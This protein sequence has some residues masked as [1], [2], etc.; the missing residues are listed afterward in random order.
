MAKR[1]TDSC[2]WNDGWFSDLPTDMKLVWLYILDTCDHAGVYKLNM[3]LLKFQT[4]T[5]RSREE[6]ENYLAERIYVSGDKWFI[7]K[8]IT[9]QYKNFFTS[10]TPAIISA[11]ELLVSHGI[12]LP[13]DNTLPTVNKQ[14]S[15]AS[16]TLIE[17]LSNDYIRTKDK[18]KAE[19]KD[20]NKDIVKDKSIIQDKVITKTK[21]K[22][23]ISPDKVNTLLFAAALGL[24]SEKFDDRYNDLSDIMDNFT[25]IKEFA[26]YL[27][28]EQTEIETLLKL[29]DD[30]A[31]IKSYF[32]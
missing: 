9:F 8:F 2:K 20:I 27:G 3:K 17:P 19:D 14:L 22:S 18:D 4:D 24:D 5:E 23:I 28:K 13:D 32:N 25:S 1:M 15:N 10:K 7:P 30:K 11:K 6:I 16:I 12:I 21:G 26:E 29:V 31:S